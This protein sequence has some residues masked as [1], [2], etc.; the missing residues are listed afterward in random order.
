VPANPAISDGKFNDA[1]MPAMSMSAI[2]ASTSQ[3]PGRIS[4][5]RAASM[6]HSSRGRPITALSP[7]FG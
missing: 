5:N 4:S 6:L 7:M 2:R 3:Q 1:Q